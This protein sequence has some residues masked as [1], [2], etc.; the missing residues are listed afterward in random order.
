MV[1][2]S[3]VVLCSSPDT[4]ILS[5]PGDQSREKSHSNY[6]PIMQVL[7]VNSSRYLP[8]MIILCP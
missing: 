4:Y 8:D 5:H 1:I 2:P 7:S 3:R 6:V